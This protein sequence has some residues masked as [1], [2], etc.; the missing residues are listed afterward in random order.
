MYNDFCKEP[1]FD[2]RAWFEMWV[3]K[4]KNRSRYNIKWDKFAHMVFQ[5]QTCIRKK[6]AILLG[7]LQVDWEWKYI[8]KM[9]FN[10][11]YTICILRSGNG[12][13]VNYQLEFIVS[14]YW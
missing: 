7:E 14:L 10:S 8:I 1:E 4:R 5:H 12:V 11:I 9:I 3:L 6:V 2:I 13:R